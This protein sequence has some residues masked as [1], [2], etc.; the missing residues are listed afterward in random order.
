M[1]DSLISR[2]LKLGISRRRLLQGSAGIIGGS[3]LPGMPAL[4]EDKPAIGTF[5]AGIS[6]SSVFIGISR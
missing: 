1:T 4:A 2:G 6:G 3:M 5:P